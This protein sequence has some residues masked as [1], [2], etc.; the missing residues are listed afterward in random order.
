MPHR[1]LLGRHVCFVRVPRVVRIVE[2]ES[3]LRLELCTCCCSVGLC[4]QDL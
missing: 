1:R 3:G 4:M 2:C